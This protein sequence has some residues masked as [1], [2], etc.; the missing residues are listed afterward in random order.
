MEVHKQTIQLSGT[1]TRG[2]DASLWQKTIPLK[3][4]SMKGWRC[5]R[6]AFS[7]KGCARAALICCAPTYR[8]ST[9]CVRYNHLYITSKHI[10][11]TINDRRDG[12]ARPRPRAC[13]SSFLPEWTRIV[14]G[15][16]TR[17]TTRLETYKMICVFG[18]RPDL[19][20]SFYKDRQI[21]QCTRDISRV[22]CIPLGVAQKSLSFL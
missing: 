4:K 11:I 2:M 19:S 9:R 13:C 5:C 17:K 20:N 6:Y 15:I 1:S 8:I 16:S 14:Y 3:G 18:Y 10:Y 21:T 12:G 7:F 22:L